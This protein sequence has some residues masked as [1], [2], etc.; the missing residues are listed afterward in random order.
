MFKAIDFISVLFFGCFLTIVNSFFDHFQKTFFEIKS[1]HHFFS[2]VTDFFQGIEHDKRDEAE[3]ERKQSGF[4]KVT[5]KNSVIDGQ[6]DGF[7][8]S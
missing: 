4:F 8:F 3:H 1:G 7:G 5:F 6:R 2:G